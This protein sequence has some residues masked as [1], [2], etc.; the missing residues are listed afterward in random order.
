MAVVEAGK[1]KIGRLET[2]RGVAVRLKGSLL[3]ESP[4]PQATSVFVLK[5][6]TDWMRPTHIM[7]VKSALLRIY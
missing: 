1:S 2:Q 7:E 4:F 6:S 5:P 3:A